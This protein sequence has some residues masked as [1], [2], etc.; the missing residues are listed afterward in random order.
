MKDFGKR[1][2]VLREECGLSQ[3]QLAEKIGASQSVITMYEQGERK[4]RHKTLKNIADV[5]DVD[6]DYLRTGRYSIDFTNA[7][8]EGANEMLA[9]N[10]IRA[11]CRKLST[12]PPEAL[13]FVKAQIEFL[14][15]GKLHQVK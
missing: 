10:E 5:F 11:V 13:K 12:L 2:R 4:P 14:L 6:I 15:K 1:L 3:M 9:S 8:I 7:G